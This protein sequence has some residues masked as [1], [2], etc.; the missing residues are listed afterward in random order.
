MHI[1]ILS[2][3]WRAGVPVGHIRATDLCHSELTALAFRLSRQHADSHALRLRWRV[4]FGG[5]SI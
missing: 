1:I 2:G 5:E 4:S 3:S